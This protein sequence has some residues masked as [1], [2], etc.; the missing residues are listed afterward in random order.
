MKL[1]LNGKNMINIM[2]V[3]L[4]M[5]KVRLIDN[6]IKELEQSKPLKKLK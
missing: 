3:I 2:N 4:N 5:K 6:K 1:N